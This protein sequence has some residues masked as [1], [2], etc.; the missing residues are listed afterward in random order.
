MNFYSRDKN[1]DYSWVQT[2]E[3]F[4]PKEFKVFEQIAEFYINKESETFVFHKDLL[5]ILR[6]NNE[7]TDNVGRSIIE[8]TV[9]NREEALE[10]IQKFP[11]VIEKL[12][13]F[14][15]VIGKDN[16][17]RSKWLSLLLKNLK[18]SIDNELYILKNST[19][20]TKEEFLALYGLNLIDESTILSLNSSNILNVEFKILKLQ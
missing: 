17:F 15:I 11:E 18:H 13:L 1:N 20:L 19:S 10:Y 5:G 12:K 7:N 8:I 14:N 3:S 16:K 9:Y 6:L 2:D 4:E